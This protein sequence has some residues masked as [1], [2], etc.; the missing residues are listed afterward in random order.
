MRLPHRSRSRLVRNQS[1]ISSHCIRKIEISRLDESTTRITSHRAPIDEHG[2]GR[3]MGARRAV[4]SI[5][6]RRVWWLDASPSRMRCLLRLR[7]WI[8]WDV[9]GSGWMLLTVQ[10]KLRQQDA[11][12]SPGQE[13]SA[14]RNPSTSAVT[15]V[16]EAPP[17]WREMVFSLAHRIG[18]DAQSNHNV[19][20]SRR[21][22]PCPLAL[23]SDRI[24][25]GRD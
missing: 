16:S 4:G 17:S 14:A 9:L 18:R 6:G 24:D 8:D 2:R 13:L 15:Q 23:G 11:S 12:T 22:K 21:C 10:V 20:T 5:D 1:N 19:G 7:F 25:W 3:W